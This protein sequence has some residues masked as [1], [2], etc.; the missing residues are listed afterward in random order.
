MMCGSSF[1]GKTGGQ[2]NMEIVLVYIGIGFLSAIG[3]YGANK[4]VLE[5]FVDPYVEQIKAE[6]KAKLPTVVEPAR[7]INEDKSK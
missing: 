2:D 1:L 4:A 3:W 7:E 5:P 6:R